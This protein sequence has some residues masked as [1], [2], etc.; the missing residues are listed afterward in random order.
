MRNKFVL[1]PSLDSGASCKDTRHSS[2][3]AGFTLLE[4]TVVLFLIALILGLSSLFFA[5]S[6]P[7]AR[8][9]AVSREL[10]ATIRQARSFA[11][12]EGTAQTVLLN[13]DALS[14]GIEGRHPRSLPRGVG[15]RVVDPLHGPIQSGTYRILFD[16]TGGI[17]GATIEV[18]N[19]KKLVRIETDPIVGT[20]TIKQ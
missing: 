4:L 7:S 17:E 10:S 6:L 12:S 2:L 20:V 18:W 15:I 19:N 11:Q 14:Y 8:L 5:G 16:A 13:F 3:S 9:S 1:S